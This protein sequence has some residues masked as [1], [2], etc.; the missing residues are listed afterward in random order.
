MTPSK[1]PAHPQKKARAKAPAARRRAALTIVQR[2]H[3]TYGDADCELCWETPLQLLVATILSA[4]STDA[5]VNR[6]T[7]ALF[8]RYCQPEDYLS[9]PEEELQQAIHSTGFFRNKARNIRGAC[10]KLLDEFGGEV[11]R[12]ME[13][14]LTLPGVARKTANVVLGTAFGIACGVVVDTHVRRLANR[15]GWTKHTDPVKIE[16]D[17][18]ALLP[19]E[20][21]IFTGHALVLHGRR[22]CHARLPQC[23]ICPLADVCPKVGVTRQAPASEL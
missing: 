10:Q 9:V 3:E 19:P 11:P 15:L 5:N 16:A 8:K 6:V 23:P 18:M 1:A 12:S 22:I 20:E 13:E 17:L 4:Q 2:L 21:W 14:L 7:P